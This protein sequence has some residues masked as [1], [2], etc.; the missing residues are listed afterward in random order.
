VLLLAFV[1]GQEHDRQAGQEHDGR[2]HEGHRVAVGE[3]LAR[4]RDQRD[5]LGGQA[6]VEG[7]GRLGQLVVRGRGGDGRQDRESE[8]AADLLRGVE[9]RRGHARV[10]VVDP[11][12]RAQNRGKTADMV[13]SDRQMRYSFSVHHGKTGVG[14]L[15]G[16]LRAL[17]VGGEE[18]LDARVGGAADTELVTFSASFSMSRIAFGWTVP[19]QVIHALS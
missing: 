17:D 16:G 7:R 14:A 8:R 13:G 9:Q 1:D 6:P 3:G 18:L 2:G 4:L 5:V 11:A 10:L 19:S 12:D 15:F